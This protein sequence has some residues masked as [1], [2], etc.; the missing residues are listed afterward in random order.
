MAISIA[1]CGAVILAGGASKR[2]GSCKA[3]LSVDG[4]TMLER[5]RQALV[6]FDQILLS[7]NDPTMGE[8]L[9]KVPDIYSGGGPLAGIHAALCKTDKKALFCVPCDLPHFS[10][11][12]PLLLMKMMPQE[13]EVF[14]CRDSTGRFHPLCGIYRRSV[15]P[16]LEDCLE[17]NQFKVMDFVNR[18][19]H[20]CLDTGNYIS[21]EIYFNMN[22]P[23][24]Y[25]K[26]SE[27]A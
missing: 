12:I 7:A 16:V 19:P 13:A 10:S 9:L 17:H 27:E 25:R 22:T 5:T 8:G 2:M 21:D 6:G 20:A 4:M 1:E 26:I 23:S 15:L 11:Q 24:D 3:L 18:V 14:I